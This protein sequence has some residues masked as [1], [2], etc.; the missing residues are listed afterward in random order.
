MTHLPTKLPFW[1]RYALT[2]AYAKVLVMAIHQRPE[3]SKR[4]MWSVWFDRGM[5]HGARMMALQA[6]KRRSQP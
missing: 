3:C 6:D 1:V 5:D 2:M 4:A